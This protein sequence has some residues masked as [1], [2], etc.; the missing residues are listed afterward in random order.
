[1]TARLADP[2]A[3]PTLATQISPMPPHP[4]ARGRALRVAA[5]SL[6]CLPTS[7]VLTF[8]VTGAFAA[9]APALQAR[10]G[11]PLFFATAFVCAATGGA[12]WAAAIARRAFA[13]AVRRRAA[14]GAG[15][16]FG[17]TTPVAL[18]GLSTAESALL[19]RAQDGAV[20]RMH[21]VFGVIFP[22]AA[23]VVVLG[24]VGGLALGLRLGRAGARLALRC[25][26]AAWAAF[27]LVAL[28]MDRAGWRIG[29]PNAEARL[30]MLVVLGVG[31]VAATLVGGLT[32]GRSLPS[33]SAPSVS[34][35]TTSE[36]AA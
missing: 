4:P 1:M 13:P 32:L 9:H 29:G 8:A 24:A 17:A 23:F 30:T 15:L 6:L 27:A 26:L 14:I 36:V 33:S 21:V 11:P 35:R 10:A 20:F 34:R 7:V 31:L 3:A 18:W 2:P 19:L 12:A 28:L 5:L 22:L 25:A 16:G